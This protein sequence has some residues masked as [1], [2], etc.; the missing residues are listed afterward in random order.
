M[1]MEN[2]SPD[3]YQ[4]LA[5]SC[6]TN[7]TKYKAEGSRETSATVWILNVPDRPI[8]YCIVHQPVPLLEVCGGLR[9]V[10]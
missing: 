8:P 7:L 10:G 1:S 9:G 3:A 2:D 6:T 4:R 5:H